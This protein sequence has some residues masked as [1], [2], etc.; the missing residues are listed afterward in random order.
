MQWRLFR[1]P[2]SVFLQPCSRAAPHLLRST[3]AHGRVHVVDNR[4][5]RLWEIPS[6]DARSH[7]E[8]VVGHDFIHSRGGQIRRH[9]SLRGASTSGCRQ[10]I[11]PETANGCSCAKSGEW[12]EEN[13]GD[14]PVEQSPCHSGFSAESK[15]VRPLSSR[16]IAWFDC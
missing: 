2:L 4:R 5:K 3:M 10:I 9:I 15:N 13:A 7:R 14:V 12:S 6:I 16:L 1:I 8:R 11:G